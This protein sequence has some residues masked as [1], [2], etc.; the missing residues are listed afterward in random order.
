MA[1]PGAGKTTFALRVATELKSNRTVDRVIVV[2]PTEHLKIQWSHAAARA[3]LALDPHF[4]NANGVVNPQ[5]DG[6]VVTYA[7]VAMHPYKH[8]AVATARRT[9]VILDEIHHGGDAKS[10]GD[11]IRTA[12]ADV[13]RRLALTGTPFRSDD[14]AIPFVRY[15]DD[16]EGYLKSKADHT[17]GSTPRAL[18][19]PSTPSKRPARGKPPS[20]RVATGFP[21]FCRPLIRDFSNCANI[22]LMRVDW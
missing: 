16:G 14:A 17:Y 3:G 4:T 5:Y 8:Y 15:E 10:W 22:C 2:V 21:Q 6:I 13:E 9:L 12:Y 7:Q 18:V 1:T 20:T 19:N 11:G